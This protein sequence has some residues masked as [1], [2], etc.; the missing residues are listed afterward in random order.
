MYQFKY[1]CIRTC[2]IIIMD[3]CMRAHT[4]TRCC[5]FISL[6]Y[7]CASFI[8]YCLRSV[9]NPPPPPTL[10]RKQDLWP[11][12]F[13]LTPQAIRR[14]AKRFSGFFSCFT[15]HLMTRAMSEVLQFHLSVDVSLRQRE[16][17]FGF[18]CGG[19]GGGGGGGGRGILVS[20]LSK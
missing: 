13:A 9:L 4:H 5:V 7:Q 16:L 6:W 11:V 19:G 14:L 20:C 18:D 15:K 10:L 3:T 8:I 2:Q 12:T 1:V 17:Q